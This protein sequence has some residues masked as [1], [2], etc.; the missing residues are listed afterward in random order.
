MAPRNEH[1]AGGPPEL[2]RSLEEQMDA[3]EFRAMLADEFPDDASEW[4]DPVSR[5]SFLTVMGASLALAGV[6]GCNPRPAP[7][8]KIFPYVTQPEQITP[9]IPLYFAT[10]MPFAGVATGVLVRSNEGRPTKVEGNPSHP[11][12]LGA[13]G[14]FA[15]SS[16][17]DLYDPDRSGTVQ[18]K[19]AP[20]VWED[21]V[22]ELRRLVKGQKEKGGAGLRFLTEPTSS[23]TL[24]G[25]FDELLKD[26]PQAK[27][28]QYDAVAGGVAEGG[29]R[30]FGKY[31]GTKYDF[32]QAGVVLA[33]DSDFL[34]GTGPGCVRYAQ[35][36]ARKRKVRKSAEDGVP[37]KDQVRLYAAECMPTPTGSVADHRLP[38]KASEVEG[39]AREVAKALG[40]PNAPEPGSTSDAV[41]KFAA[42][43]AADLK[44]NGGKSIV[45]PGE[46][47]PDTVHALAHAINSHLGNFGKTVSFVA[48]PTARPSNQAQA[49][50]LKSLVEEMKAGKVEV[51][52]IAGANPVYTAPADL[53]FL[54]ALK[55]VKVSFHLGQYT[56]ETAV[57]CDWHLPEAHYL[58]TWGD[59]RAY[60]GTASIQQP[61]IA[62][63]YTGRSM[64]EIMAAVLE[65]NVWSGR[66]VVKE[67]WRQRFASE[68]RT[69]AFESA[70][71]K[72]LQ[73][74]VV[75][76]TAAADESV[77]LTNDWFRAP[78]AS[79]GG[80]KSGTYEVVFRPDPTL[81]DGRFANNGWLQ[82]LPRP[83]TKLTW[84]NA[85]LV[86][87]K[88]AKDLGL[89]QTPRWNT[90]ERGRMEVDVVEFTYRGK[91]VR[92]PAWAQ[93]GIPDGVIVLNLGYGRDRAG[94]LGTGVGF[95]AYA[96]RTAESPWFDA[97]AAD[98]IK[99]TGE[100]YI[101]GCTQAF[102]GMQGRKPVRF[103]TG[104]QFAG[105]SKEAAEQ[106]KKAIAP[107]AATG[108]AKL[109]N[110][111]VPGPHEKRNYPTWEPGWKPGEHKHDDHDHKSGDGHHH[112]EPDY[113]LVPLTMVYPTDEHPN[114]GRRWAMAIDLTV[115]TGCNV[116]M[117]ACQAENNIPVV[118]KGQVTRG[119]EMHWI[120]V[121]RYYEG[122][123]DNAASLQTHIQPVPCQ[124]CEKA[125]CE[126]V[127]PVA[128]TVHSADGLNDMVYNRCVGTRYCSNNCPYKVRRFN[129]LTYAD[130]AT[131]SYKLGRNPDVTVRSR[132]VMEKCTYCVQRIR[133]AEIDAERHGRPIADGEIVT[134]C[135]AACPSSAIIFGD[136]GDKAS[137]LNRW[138]SEPT[139]YGL[140]AELNTMPRTTYLA[141]VRNPNPA[142]AG[143]PKGA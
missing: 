103:V 65:K 136:I 14:L 143:T 19:G 127:C 75:E 126:V 9:G 10:V 61:L 57:W 67:Y 139:N 72:W 104:V 94:K 53:E 99:K 100:T 4:T 16:I 91:T 39:F 133:G 96:V 69:G 24:V 114:R 3:P 98:Q 93:P 101:L 137:V 141:S 138:K 26:L 116:C 113:R 95:N 54:N 71:Q 77:T 56:D 11:G 79:P 76:N 43:A 129:F 102:T 28:V 123:P 62:P 34:S 42:A 6:A 35:D 125:P 2:W 15:Q 140:L 21:A 50:D 37:A 70:W 131:E 8:R 112:H 52:V 51:L 40:V 41:K 68:K 120:R 128:A 44:A 49:A 132:G 90:G 87:P 82:E 97:G 115:C 45:I 124:Q 109:I 110:D 17:L 59:G 60:D 117:L 30:A 18:Y 25:L 58:E 85:V 38:L 78:A 5:R 32:T 83:S 89:T 73:L 135:Q 107:A 23:P 118:G 108:E 63:L 119:R 13:T 36:F 142:L 66:E 105:E 1:A 29:R 130:F 86:S 48:S 80:G 31:V 74:G 88:A 111:L 20:R 7:A 106:F 12:S 22:N 33:L 81:Y 121:D 84:D 46:T 55:Q 134:A 64:I 122:D 27:W 47:Q 92:G